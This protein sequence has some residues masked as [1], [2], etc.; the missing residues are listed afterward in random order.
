ML[1]FIAISFLSHTQHIIIG[2]LS[3]CMFFWV[4]LYTLEHLA[5]KLV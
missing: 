1:I 2:Q 4:H 5:S 3:F